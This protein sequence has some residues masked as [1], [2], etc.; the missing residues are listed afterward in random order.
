MDRHDGSARRTTALT[1]ADGG[2]SGSGRRYVLAATILGSAMA[3]IDGSVV[4]IA[5]PR[6]QVELGAGFAALQWVVNGYTLM[7]GAFLVVGGGLG[8]RLGRRRIFLLGLS[9]FA[10]A[11]ILCAAAPDAPTLIGG[12]IVQGLA[13]AAMVPQSLAIISATFPNDM[14]GAAIGVWAGASAVTTALGPPLG[15]LLID[16]LSW[17]AAFWINIPLA[18]AALWLTLR[19]VP[20]SRDPQAGG[21]L[22]WPGAALAAFALGAATLGLTLLGGPAGGAF[23]G[24]ACIFAGLLAILPLT[25]VERRAAN[26]VVPPALFRSRVFAGMNVVT[27]LLYGSLS[28]VLFLLPFALTGLRGLSAAEIGLTMLPLGLLIGVFSRPAG[29]AA[30][31]YGA[32]PFVAGGALLVG[33]GCVGLSLPLAG[34]ASGVLLPIVLLALGMAAAV[35]PLTTAVMNSAPDAQSGAASGVNNAASRLAGLLAVALLGAL[36]SYLFAG[37]AGPDASFGALPP[38]GHPLRGIA[39]EAFGRAYAAAMAMAALWAFAGAVA[40]WVS[41]SGTSR[42]KGSAKASG[43]SGRPPLR[44]RRRRRSP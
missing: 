32:R 10:A 39:V 14:R 25:F 9:A 38:P 40:A 7:L 6:M 22:D 31:R 23:L 36:A 35:S 20:E 19:G 8:D 16:S 30:D 21:P 3:F 18:A 41:L 28:G 43:P 44:L 11:S 29:A 26:P 17:R 1:A 15:G 27:L 37:D 33:A 5:L 24:G 2:S 4:T 34:F 13:A 12:R 42:P